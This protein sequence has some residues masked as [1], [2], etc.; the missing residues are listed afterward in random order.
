MIPI[1]GCSEHYSLQEADDG[2][3]QHAYIVKNKE[4]Y[5]D[6]STLRYV[7]DPKGIKLGGGPAKDPF[8][9][10]A[11][12]IEQLATELLQREVSADTPLRVAAIYLSTGYDNKTIGTLREWA[13]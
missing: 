3:W 12:R 5:W 8:G 1:T 7:R 6:D 13:H 11:A 2:F 9:A 4:A 10:G